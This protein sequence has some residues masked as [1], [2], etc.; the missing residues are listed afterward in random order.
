MTVA[1]IECPNDLFRLRVVAQ[2]RQLSWVVCD[3]SFRSHPDESAATLT[4]RARL[5]DVPFTLG[6]PAATT[7]NLGALDVAFTETQRASLEKASAVE[8]GFPH[9]FLARPMTRSVV[10]GGVKIAIGS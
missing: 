1:L 3:R 7:G 10:L 4:P 5:I 2:R 8:L 6:W 9:D